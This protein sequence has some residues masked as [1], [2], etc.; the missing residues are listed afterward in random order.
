MISKLQLHDGW[1]FSF[2]DKEYSAL[3]PGCVHSDLRRH[4]LIPD[5]FWGANELDIQWIEERDWT[6]NL[7]FDVNANLLQNENVE[8]V[9][10]GLD[11]LAT[12]VLN[13]HQ[14]AQ[15][16]NMFIGYRFDVKA[17][18]QAGENSLQIHFANPMD[19]IR[20]QLETYEEHQWNDPIGGRSAIRK[21][22]CSFGWDWG[23]RLATSGIWQP[24][25]LEAW[26]TN[27]LETVHITQHH[28]DGKVRLELRPTTT[29]PHE[30][31]YR[32]T[33]KLDNEI[34]VETHELSFAV[35]DAQ[36]WWPNGLGAQSLYEL[37]VELLDE[38]RVLDWWNRRI[39]LRTIELQTNPDE[40][41]ESFQ[42]AVNGVPFFAK[43]S[44]MVPVIAPITETTRDRIDDILE[45][46]K[47]AHMNMIRSWGGNIYESDD[48]YDLCDEKGLLV[49]QDLMFACGTYRG[50]QRF[51]DLVAQEIEYQTQR[52]QHRTSLAVW[53]GS[54]ETEWFRKEI[55]ASPQ[56]TEDYENLYYKTIPPVLEKFDGTRRYWPSSPH[57]PDGWQG[58]HD[59]QAAGDQHTWSVWF[60]REPA[61][62][63]EKQGF[64][65]CSE[66]GMQS[67]CSQET[68]ELFC[69]PEDMN[70]FSPAMENH[71]KSP[72][73]NGLILDYVARLYRFPK[74]Y[75]ALAY[76]SQL[77]QAFVVKTAIEHFRRISPR[78]MGALYW[79][80]N[81]CWPG[82]SWSSLEFDGRWK[83]LQYEAKRFNAPALL[84]VHVPG[85]ESAGTI[86][87][88]KSTIGE[89]H[90]YTVYDAREEKQGTIHWELR[91]LDGRVLESG[92]HDVT[93]RFGESEKHFSHDFSGAMREHGAP[94]IYGRAWLAIDG[95]T[96][97]RQT[98]LLT[99]PRFLNLQRAPIEAQIEQ[100]SDLEYSFSFTSGVYQHS[101]QFHLKG[102]QYRADDNFFDLHP[103]QV[104]VVRVK[105]KQPVS[106]DELRAR[107]TTMS[108]VDSY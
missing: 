30:H 84:S 53:C 80:L 72:A 22:Q 1:T 33:L 92:S 64:R 81:D 87:R 108:L 77:N 66:F 79:Q 13:G 52:L 42:F 68:A 19:Y 89:A 74:D 62:F 105:L 17:H 51:L 8:L 90:F 28:S 97:S 75:A 101:V 38:G 60:G 37:K 103:D 95:E 63:Y 4:E 56:A 7:R 14:I 91:H 49:W 61:K 71:Q 12:I 20:K 3:V 10:D 96:V 27:R 55:T 58:E 40:W 69:A 43:G 2:D 70:V 59:F 102:T 34:V 73:G 16:E 32:V 47:A 107:L 98:I 41:G 35:P 23:P 24:I 67:Y 9:C 18:L 93:L 54:N 86:N 57:H 39:G 50:D 82:A 11:T 36:L 29:N 44:N 26:N 88:L 106:L 25:R 94:N 21:Q 83:A 46:A 31:K 6:Y 48:F 78:C 15:T 65:F 104:H 5:P 85:E 45:S 76:L 100:T 99:A